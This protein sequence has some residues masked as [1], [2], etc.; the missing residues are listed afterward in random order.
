[1]GNPTVTVYLI[2]ERRTPRRAGLYDF[3][4]IVEHTLVRHGYAA[5]LRDFQSFVILQLVELISLPLERRPT[6]ILDFHRSP[7]LF[8]G[9]CIKL[10]S[11]GVGKSRFRAC[12]PSFY[13]HAFIRPGNVVREFHGDTRCP[14]KISSVEFTF[15]FRRCSS[16]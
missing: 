3:I 13:F 11:P 2:Q 10:F 4:R 8:A 9:T 15:L 14:V 16:F 5:S 7:K 6:L 12:P 1:M